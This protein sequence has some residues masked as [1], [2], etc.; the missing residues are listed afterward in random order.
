M[1]MDDDIGGVHLH[2]LGL[3][4]SALHVRMGDSTGT[5]HVE[6]EW[7]RHMV[8]GMD[9]TVSHFRVYWVENEFMYSEGARIFMKAKQSRGE[10]TV[11]EMFSGLTGWS[12]VIN[13]NTSIAVEKDKDT[14]LCCA[15]KLNAPMLTADQYIWEILSGQTIPVV[16]LWDSATNPLTWVAAGLANVGM[17]V[18]S[19]P[20]PPWSTAANAWG[21]D[22]ED[23]ACFEQFLTWNAKLRMPIVTVENVPGIVKHCDFRPMINRIEKLGLKLMLTGCFSSKHVLPVNRERW[24]G[25]FVHSDIVVDT[26]RVQMANDVSFS[27]HSFK[28]VATSPSIDIV[29]VSHVHMT[30]MERQELA[31]PQQALVAM[32]T[33]AYAPQWLKDKTQSND[34]QMLIQGRVVELDQQFRGFMAMYGSQHLLDDDLLRKKGLHTVIMQ[35]E[36]GYRYFSPWEMLSAM[37]YTPD[38]ILPDDITKAWRMC[39]NGIACAHVWLAIYKTHVMLGTE[40]PFTPVNDVCDQVRDFQQNA[41][42][43][44]EYCTQRDEG[45]WLL[46]PCVPDEDDDAVFDVKRRKCASTCEDTSIEPTA[47]FTIDQVVGTRCFSSA[48]DFAQLDDPR[49]IAAAMINNV[50]VVVVLRHCEKHWMM[51]VNGSPGDSVANFIMKGLPHAKATS[52]RAFTMQGQ[53]VDWNTVIGHTSVKVLEFTPVSMPVAVL[54]PKFEKII[55]QTDT[56]WTIKTLVAYVACQ[57]QCNPDAIAIQ[58]EQHVLKD[59]EY[60]GYYDKT[61]YKMTFKSCMPGYVSWDH[62]AVDVKD[63]GL[64]PTTPTCHRVVARHP[65]KKVVRACA[66]Q[67]NQSI[68]QVLQTLF[69]DLATSVTWTPFN[70]GEIISHDTKMHALDTFVVQWETFRPMQ[71]TTVQRTNYGT[72]I[73]SAGHQVAFAMSGVRIAMRSPLKV[74]IQELWCPRTATLAQIAASFLEQTQANVSMLCAA[75]P[76]ILDPEVTAGQVDSTE[77]INFRICPLLGGGKHDA[78]K[79]RVRDML[80]TKGVPE[81]KVAERVTNLLNKVPIDHIAKYKGD[82][83]SA[84]W[85]KLK[86]DASDAKYRLITPAELKAFQTSQRKNKAS[87]PSEP[88]PKKFPKNRSKEYDV[89]MV[90]VDMSHFRANDDPVGQLEASRFGPDQTGLCVITCKEADKFVNQAIRSCDPLAVLIIGDDAKRYGQPF[91]MPAHLPNGDPIVTSAVLKQYGE[92][93][94]TFALQLPATKVE[95]MKSTVI[96]FNIMR[97]QVAQWDDTAQPLNYLGIQVPVLRGNNLL[98]AWSIRAFA[99]GKAVNHSAAEEWH[100]YLRVAD[101]LP[102]QVLQRSGSAGIY[103]VPKND[104]KKR[105]TRFVAFQV[106]GKSVAEVMNRA[107][108]IPESLGI[109]RMGTGFGIRCRRENASQMR[110]RLNP[111][112]AYTWSMRM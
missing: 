23:G 36:Q 61:E 48:P 81:D 64:V 84:F 18:A 75:G 82:D 72:P 22:T 4:E 12:S 26:I 50:G 21:L 66:Y 34:P 29:D 33:S 14:A 65:M 83:D 47:P 107:E 76:R 99:K 52:F 78:V 6:K 7:M 13:M 63:A 15:R 39:G 1:A 98:A 55:V 95:Q 89:E 104:E 37:G 74:K 45:F 17:V 68:A 2:V 49:A 77:V 100:G 58:R 43:L 5:L 110:A 87:A 103:M 86:D 92:V 105:D 51:V 40:S 42:H 79:T 20:C 67:E 97:S 111:E 28:A 109:V 25:T 71:V 73:N 3:G 44:S 80:M 56:T 57:L 112:S 54:V 27:N 31:V 102:E 69:P 101:Q 59:E 24:L 35:D 70:N 85:S 19:P 108:A 94:I 53:P 10:V 9:L 91:S 46:H 11:A 8:V 90:Q 30:C 41:I 93:P 32:G 106:P 16:V 88:K 38:T 96:E 60:L 62:K